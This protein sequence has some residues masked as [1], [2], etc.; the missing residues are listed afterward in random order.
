MQMK[1]LK[2]DTQVHRDDTNHKLIKD[3]STYNKEYT[4]EQSTELSLPLNWILKSIFVGA[5]MQL[6]PWETLDHSFSF[7]TAECLLF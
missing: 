4:M 7:Q 3:N 5:S 1:K 2:W 6:G